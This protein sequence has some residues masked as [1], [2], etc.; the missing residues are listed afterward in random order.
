MGA[1]IVQRRYGAVCLLM[2]MASAFLAAC[3]GGGGS[4]SPS[5]AKEITAFSLE[6]VSSTIKETNKTIAVTMPYGTNVTSL[7]ATF[8]SSGVDV[9]VGKTSQISDVTANDFTNPVTYMVTAADGTT[10]SYTVIVAVAQSYD[11][12]ITAFTL[13][14]VTGVINE[15]NKS[16]AVIMPFGTNVNALVATF[17]ITGTKVMVGAVT[18]VSGTTANNFSSPVSYVVYPS[19]GAA[20][21]Y[22]VTVAVAASSA[23]AI[24]AFSLAGV[25]GVINE[26]NKTVA[27]TMPFGTNAAALVATFTTTGASVAVGATTQISGTT[28]NDFTNPLTYTVTAADGSTVD[29]TVGMEATPTCANGGN[30]YPT[31]TPPISYKRVQFY[32]H[33]DF[34][35][36]QSLSEIQQNLSGYINDLNVI[37]AKNTRLRLTY[38]PNDV[39][40]DQYSDILS[41]ADNPINENFTYDVDIFKSTDAS[42]HGGQVAC[43]GFGLNRQ[44]IKGLNWVK[45]YSRTEINDSTLASLQPE[46]DDYYTHQLTTLA[47]EIAHSMGAGF[48]EYYSLNMDDVTGTVPNLKIYLYDTDNFYWKKRRNVEKDPLLARGSYSVGKAIM[49]TAQYSSLTARIFNTTLDHKGLIDNFS[50]LINAWSKDYQP[51]YIQVIDDENGAAISN[52]LVSAYR[53]QA[54]DGVYLYNEQITDSSGNAIVDIKREL[55]GTDGHRFILFKAS[56]DGYLPTGDALSKFDLE[57][58]YLND[59]GQENDFQFTGT[60]VLRATK[61][62]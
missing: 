1:E 35:Q 40:T 54:I 20:V 14:G 42:S 26:T 59:G 37:L 53:Q 25:A 16:I 23:K 10:A 6:G 44:V 43:D 56:C 31:C 34:L 24:T 12:A 30:D 41:C 50:Y 51:V 29:Y 11:K 15:T 45:F 22:T 7:V 46:N 19:N 27:V 8:A 18:Q 32:V 62:N 33:P 4:T 39:R 13:G 28:A 61:V 47:H 5:S 21:S 57:A 17:T 60:I 58:K 55:D 2:F 48:G 49:D 52:C 9:V 3:N 38:D 36:T